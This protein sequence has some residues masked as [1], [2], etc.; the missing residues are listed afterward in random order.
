MENFNYS[1]IGNRL[2]GAMPVVPSGNVATVEMHFIFSSDWDG[3]SVRAT[4][5]KCGAVYEQTIVGGTA[6][7]PAEVMRESGTFEMGV[8]GY[9]SDG[10]TVTVRISTNMIGGR[11]IDGAYAAGMVPGHE[12]DDPSDWEALMNHLTDYENPHKVNSE[13]LEDNPRLYGMLTI[14]QS[15]DEG[16]TRGA[17]VEVWSAFGYVTKIT[18]DGIDLNPIGTSMGG[19]IRNLLDPSDDMDA[20]PKGWAENEFLKKED[21]ENE[22]F[23]KS[24]GEIE[25]A[26]SAL[27]GAFGSA[28]VS[29]VDATND[30]AVPNVRKVREMIPPVDHE[31]WTFELEGGTTV[32]KEVALWRS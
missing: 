29:N 20:V 11:V 30:Y 22:Y 28:E 14:E 18:P 23:K 7:I 12:K 31:T 13:Q 10:E 6:K 2:T 9:E 8:I 19:H 3:L 5:K 1:A 21:A 16:D 24:G 17:A 32:A 25:G 4:F 15:R 27:S 26:M